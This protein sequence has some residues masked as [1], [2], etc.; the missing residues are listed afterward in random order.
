MITP[1]SKV[2]DINF[3]LNET[4]KTLLT[5]VQTG[6]TSIFRFACCLLNHKHK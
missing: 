1:L 4:S 6:K 5:K 3:N 2:I